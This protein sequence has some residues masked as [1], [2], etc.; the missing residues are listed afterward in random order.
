M[1]TV[2][3]KQIQGEWAERVKKGEKTDELLLV[4]IFLLGGATQW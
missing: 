3:R 1:K 4:D 2:T